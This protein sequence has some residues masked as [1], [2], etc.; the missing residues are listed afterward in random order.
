MPK[1]TQTDSHD[2][3]SESV[4]RLRHELVGFLG[5]Q[6]QRLADTAGE[7]VTDL[8][9]K[10]GSAVPGGAGALPKVGARVLHGESPA[11]SVIKEGAKGV[12]DKTAGTVKKAVGG[13]K[14]E[15]DKKG[16][17]GGTKVTNVIETIDIGMPLRACYNHWTEFEKFGDFMKGVQGVQRPDETT[18]DWKLKIG[19]SSRGW[20]ATVEEQIP[21]ERI[22]WTSEGA[23][24]STRGVV[25]FHEITPTLTRIVVV[26][27]YYPSG[28]FEKTANLWRAQGR[29]LRLDLK[30]FQRHVTLEAD[31]VP[32][33]WRGEIR[34][35]EVVRSHED[36]MSA[37]HDESGENGENG[38]QAGHDDEHEDDEDFDD[39]EED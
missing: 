36:A 38:E 6:V 35:G 20:H 15:D 33:G 24:A 22:E 26:V 16:K 31:E 17:G 3:L 5:A 21:D 10:L 12:K 9:E 32:E 39:E 37:E 29:R 28:F 23:Q 11:T 14:K 13:G 25:T 2:G 30:H 4:E 34:D 27:E 8:T 1:P 7:R 19:P 18:S